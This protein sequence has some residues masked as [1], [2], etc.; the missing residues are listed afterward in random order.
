[1]CIRF[2]GRFRNVTLISAYAPTEDSQEENK[3]AFYNKLHRECSKIPKYDMLVILGD[4]NF[5]IGTKAFIKNVAGKF[6]LHTEINN[7]G[8]MLSELT[9]TNNFIIKST[10]F[11]H[12]RIHKGTW[13]IPGSERTNQK[14][15]VLVSRRHGSS[16]LDVK[17]ERGPKCDSEH[18]LVK[19]KIKDRLAR[20]DNNKSYKRR[21]WKVD[22]LKEPEQS[23]L[24]QKTLKT[25]SEALRIEP[26]EN[27]NEQSNSNGTL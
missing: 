12:K 23:Q 4:F 6:I 9:M 24:Y 15:H 8:K 27:E 25:K 2:K 11:N 18:Y 26:T 22:K 19:V 14:D 20:I 3:H 16:I 10:R 1:M 5:Q 17:T 21:K 13:K 7:N